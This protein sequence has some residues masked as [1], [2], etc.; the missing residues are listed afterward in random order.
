M[1]HAHNVTRP[2]EGAAPRHDTNEMNMKAT[3][4]HTLRSKFF[5][6]RTLLV[7]VVM[8]A[9]PRLM[10]LDGVSFIPMDEDGYYYDKYHVQMVVHPDNSYTITEQMDIVFTSPRHGIY[11]TLNNDVWI[12]RDLSERQD[13]SSSAIR[14][15]TA[16]FDN[17]KVNA[18]CDIF[19]EDGCTDLRIGSPSTL[20][21]GPQHFDITYTMQVPADRVPQADL[22]FYSLLGTGEPCST[23]Q[24]SFSI[25]FDKPVPEASLAQLQLFT[26]RVGSDDDA[27]GRAITTLT[28]TLIEG[29]LDHVLPRHAVSAYLPLPEGYF[30]AVTPWQTYVAWVLAALATA[31]LLYVLYKEFSGDNKVTPIVTFNP[32]AGMTSAEVGTLIDCSVDD[33]DLISLIPWLASQGYIRIEK[34]N[35]E[36]VLVRQDKEVGD[37]PPYVSKLYFAMFQ[38]GDKFYPSKPTS[39]SFGEGWLDARETITKQLRGKLNEPDEG[40]FFWLIVGIL[41]T[42]MAV[43]WASAAYRS[44]YFG[45][46][47]SLCIG[48]LASVI[49][50]GYANKKRF[51]S[52]FWVLPL[53]LLPFAYFCDLVPQSIIRSIQLFL[54]TFT[55][56]KTLGPHY[57]EV[58]DDLYIPRL[59]VDGLILLAVVV[60]LL[61]MRLYSLSR[62]RRQ[63]LG[64]LMGLR[65]FILTAEKDRLKMLLEGNEQYFYN[66]LPYA[67]AFG[68]SQ[69]WADKFQ[70]LTVPVN[71]DFDAVR[72]LSDWL[73]IHNSLSSSSFRHGIM[74]ERQARA[75]DIALDLAR[76]GG[77]LLASSTFSKGGGGYSG[78][79]FGGGGS[80]S[81]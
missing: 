29:K 43:A 48:L 21:E 62:Y 65:E 76:E 31:C 18:R 67:V 5:A 66:I 8:T 63:H 68:L 6:L 4:L 77:S 70:G 61:A 56:Q 57:A 35:G 26:G 34:Q 74:A 73:Y 2:R 37:L 42:G 22:F 33:S 3:P 19:D 7:L 54:Y 81:W 20:L 78:G 75:V 50:G 11:R 9:V 55:G 60:S 59:C 40:S 12:K 36:V 16:V 80:R 15:Y 71:K 58:V 52:L 23:T 49:W 72:N 45:V 47:V 44:W 28:P 79:G 27:A 10:A 46:I 38:K 24:F 17:I 1:T 39:Q 69:Q 13:R 25:S 53:T 30:E 32:P 64:T 41:L 51:K 14:H